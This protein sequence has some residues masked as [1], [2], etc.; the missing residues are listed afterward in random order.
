MDK[1]NPLFFKKDHALILYQNYKNGAIYNNRK[2]KNVQIGFRFTA[3][4]ALINGHFNTV[5]K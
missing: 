2:L 1:A 4:V 5:N 3:L